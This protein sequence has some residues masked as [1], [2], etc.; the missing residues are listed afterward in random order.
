VPVQPLPGGGEED[1][2][3]AAFADREVD[4]AGGPRCELDDGFRAAL[5]GD[6][7]GAVAAFGTQCLDVGAGSFRDAEPVEREQ[8][9]QSVLGGGA[10]PG[11]DQQ[12][13]DLVAVQPGGVGLVVNPGP[14][15]MGR[16]RVAEQVFLDRVAVQAGDGGQPPGDRRP[17][18]ASCLEVAGEQFDVGAADGE[19][20][21][22]VL[23]APGGELAQ[24]QSGGL[25]GHA[26][27][28]RQ[29]PG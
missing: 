29:E 20:A 17:G 4:R 24:V 28:P 18:P 23:V 21:Q 12:G 1:R 11:G 22:A 10:E 27:V 5:A 14:T 3:G 2:P 25:S 15:N 6:R 16:R 13:A 7:Q 9:D 19:Q 8:G 26:A